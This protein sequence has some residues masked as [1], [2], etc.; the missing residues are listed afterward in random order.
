M[1]EEIKDNLKKIAHGAE[2]RLTKLMLRW[3]Y[4]KLG[5][6][7]PVD[8]RLDRESRKIAERA[9]DIIAVRGKTIWKEF[10]KVYSKNRG[11]GKDTG[12]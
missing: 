1:D 7:I 4:K 11:E 3:N 6:P 2:H 12:K 9:N 8:H 5:K 10:K